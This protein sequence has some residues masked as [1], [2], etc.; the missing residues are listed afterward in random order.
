MGQHHS[1]LCL[2]VQPDVFEDY[3]IDQPSEIIIDNSLVK[4]SGLDSATVLQGYMSSSDVHQLPDYTEKIGSALAGLDSIPNAVGLGA[5][6]ISMLLELI[7][8]KKDEMSTGDILRRVFAEEKASEIRD[9]MD[10]YIRRLK[11][12]LRDSQLQLDDTR[13]IE[14]LLSTQITRLK[15]FNHNHFYIEQIYYVSVK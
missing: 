4:F 10:E 7:M 14:N 13:R 2:L 15:V 5:L 6:V 3:L 12:N 11:T 9:L 8:Q 1:E